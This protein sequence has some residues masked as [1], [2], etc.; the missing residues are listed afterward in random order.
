MKPHEKRN[1]NSS[2]VFGTKIE[3]FSQN[4]IKKY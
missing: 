3:L 2:G 1:R 4:F